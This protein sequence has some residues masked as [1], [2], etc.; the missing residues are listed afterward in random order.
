[1][2]ALLR[3][4]SLLNLTPRKFPLA[5]KFLIRSAP[6]DED[7]AFFLNYGTDDG[8]IISAHILKP[9]NVRSDPTV[10]RKIICKSN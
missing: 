10:Y 8:G 6:G 4:F 1:M 5:G 9:E 3:R 7:L 2:Q